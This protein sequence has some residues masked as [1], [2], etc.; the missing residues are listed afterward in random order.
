M[1]RR[2]FATG[3]LVL[4][5]AAIAGREAAAACPAPAPDQIVVFESVA[6]TGN[7]RVLGIGR[8]AS[9]TDFAPVRNET[10]SSISVGV[11]VRAV[12]YQHSNFSGRKAHYEG[13]FDYNM[14]ADDNRASSI[15]VFANSGGPAAAWY[16]NTFPSNRE[17]YWSHEAQGL[18][19]SDA[20]ASWYIS[21]NQQPR[22]LKVPYNE[23]LN[24]LLRPGSATFVWL[25]D[26][27]DSRT[28]H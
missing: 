3:A 25:T 10:I 7:C 2:S 5:L 6:R 13:G 9:A 24:G 20:Q 27:F 17:N 23:N 19:H 16:L 22:I 4:G 21:Q 14:G 15:E 28:R 26:F 18:A 11:S 12:L 8:F 1:K